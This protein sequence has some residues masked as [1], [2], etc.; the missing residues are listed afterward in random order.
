MSQ[1]KA[2]F[3]IINYN[4]KKYLSRLIRSLLSQ[5]EKKF[6]IIIIDND[7]KDGSVEF[8]SRKY[9]SLTLIRSPNIGFGRGCNLGAK[10]STGEFL[11]F[12]NPDTYVPPTFLSKY[13]DFYSLKSKESPKPI[14][15]LNSRVVEYG[16][17]TSASRNCGRGVID[18]FGTPKEVADNRIVE[19]SFFVF[20]TALFISRKAFIKAHG[21][22]PNIFLYGEE[23]DLCWRLVNLGYRHL[24]DNDNYFYHFGGGSFGDNRPYQ[25]SLM[26]YGCFIASFTNYSAITL[27]ILFPIYLLYLASLLIFVPFA[28]NLNFEYS[29][30]ILKTFSQFFSNHRNIFKYRKICLRTKT[31]NDYNLTKYLSL[32]PSIVSRVLGH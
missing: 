2:S 21:F 31:V 12:L 5:N 7:S 9:P 27:I 11:I 23:I 4:G 13:L 30:Q 24:V 14:G 17:K 15:C 18:I 16:S 28:K 22:N 6:E 32:T 8:I 25:T 29:I 20:G 26:T 10:H 19:D 1:I 3:I